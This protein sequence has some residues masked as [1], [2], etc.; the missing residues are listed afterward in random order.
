MGCKSAPRSRR[1]DDGDA[2]AKRNRESDSSGGG[3]SGVQRHIAARH[4]QVAEQQREQT[5]NQDCR[6]REIAKSRLREQVNRAG[7]EISGDKE[8]TDQIP[9]SIQRLAPT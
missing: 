5:A 9:D 1:D 7:A 4:G 2:S 6:S 8:G 3:G